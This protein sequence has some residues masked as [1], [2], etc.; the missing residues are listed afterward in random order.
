MHSWAI[1]KAPKEGGLIECG[2][3]GILQYSLSYSRV[4]NTCDF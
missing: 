2:L 4:L 1:G 3:I